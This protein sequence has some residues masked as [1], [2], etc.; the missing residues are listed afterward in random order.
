[1]FIE[2]RNSKDY[3]FMNDIGIVISGPCLAELKS[4]KKSLKSKIFL[5]NIK[6][7]DWVGMKGNYQ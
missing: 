2:K 7:P 5:F 3:I 1:M 6:I 4:I